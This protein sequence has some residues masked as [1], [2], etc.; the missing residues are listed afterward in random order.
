MTQLSRLGSYVTFGVAQS[1]GQ[2]SEV[3]RAGPR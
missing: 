1:D 2:T 3:Q